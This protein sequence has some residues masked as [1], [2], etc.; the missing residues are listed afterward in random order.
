[1]DVLL[2]S[3][4]QAETD[5]TCCFELFEDVLTDQQL[6]HRSVVVLMPDTSDTHVENIFVENSR[7]KYP[8][9][10][11]IWQSETYKWPLS[12]ANQ[13]NYILVQGDKRGQTTEA[14]FEKSF[15]MKNKNN[16]MHL[17]SICAVKT[18]RIRRNS[19]RVKHRCDQC[20]MLNVSSLADM[21]KESTTLH[22][23]GIASVPFA[24]YDGRRGYLKG[25]DI[26]VVKTVAEK[27]NASLFVHVFVANETEYLNIQSAIDPLVNRYFRQRCVRIVS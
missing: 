14:F 9:S 19:T 20:S 6:K 10:V 4:D 22:A 7:R 2:N 13:N 17:S 11:E 23:M 26:S 15:S 1:M 24:Y 25:V 16:L 18:V 21:R 5:I 8:W 3:T 27:L 12:N